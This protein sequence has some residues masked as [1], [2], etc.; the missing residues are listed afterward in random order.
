MTNTIKTLKSILDYVSEAK[1]ERSIVKRLQEKECYELKTIL[2]GNFNEKIEFPFPSG[3]PPFDRAENQIEISEQKLSIL[4]KLTK[5]SKLKQ[6][7]KEMALINLL[8]NVSSGDADII[9]AMKDGELESLYP[10]VTRAA[11]QKAFPD[12]KI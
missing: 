4:G 11:T 1:Q 10:K 5:F 6:I 2:Q 8:E 12:L 3:P 9:I 7:E